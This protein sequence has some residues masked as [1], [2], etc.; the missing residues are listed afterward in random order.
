MSVIVINNYYKPEY[1]CRAC[2]IVTALEKLGRKCE[3]FDYTK[4]DDVIK[5]VEKRRIEGVL[6]S[7]SSAHLRNSENLSKYNAEIEFIQRASVPLLGI[8][9][10]HQLIGK[11]FGSEIGRFPSFLE[12]FKGVEILEP[13]DLFSSWK[14]GERILLCES[15]Q[16]FI[17]NLPK[18]FTCL[19]RSKDCKIEAMKHNSL[20]IYGVQAHMERFLDECRDGLQIFKNFLKNVVDRRFQKQEVP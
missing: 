13:N 12:G 19:A 4:I 16:D 7:G 3:L 14:K 6:L 18:N 17:K 10:G 8:C 15:H 1:R 5:R 11:A 2:Q 20:P 9:F